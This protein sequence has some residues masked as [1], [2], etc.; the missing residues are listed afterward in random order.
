MPMKWT[1][2]T[3]TVPGWHWWRASDEHGAWPHKIAQI[4]GVLYITTFGTDHKRELYIGGEWAGPI[5]EPEE[6]E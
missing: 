3:P 4:N 5:P 2:T 1:T 6:S